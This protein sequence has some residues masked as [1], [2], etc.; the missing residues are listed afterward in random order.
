[1]P[2]HY[3]IQWSSHPLLIRCVTRPQWVLSEHNANFLQ[4][5]VGIMFREK[6]SLNIMS[7]FL[8]HYNVCDILLI[9]ASFFHFDGIGQM[10]QNFVVKFHIFFSNFSMLM[11]CVYTCKYPGSFGIKIECKSWHVNHIFK[12]YYLHLLLSWWNMQW[13]WGPIWM[14]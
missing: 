7:T 11:L 13:C 6:F 8:Y 5:K 12:F 1:M 14:A 9:C 10:R 2:S 4:R 3:L